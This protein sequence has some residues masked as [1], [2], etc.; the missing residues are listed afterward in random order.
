MQG[1]VTHCLLDWSH[2]RMFLMFLLGRNTETSLHLALNMCLNVR[3]T[4]MEDKENRADYLT[5]V[6]YELW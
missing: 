4:K 2:S 5:G 3:W 6:R 1:R